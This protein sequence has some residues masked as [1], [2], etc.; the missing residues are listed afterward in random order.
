MAVWVPVVL[1]IFSAGG[2]AHAAVS[3]VYYSPSLADYTIEALTADLPL[4][5]TATVLSEDRWADEWTAVF[6]TGEILKRPAGFVLPASF[7]ASL[8][9][10]FTTESFVA[11]DESRFRFPQKS[12]RVLL[13]LQVDPSL[14]TAVN[15]RDL[16]ILDAPGE[17]RSLVAPFVYDLTLMPVSDNQRVLEI[18]RAELQRVPPT[19]AARGFAVYPLVPDWLP[20]DDRLVP[21][22]RRWVKSDNPLARCLAVEIFRAYP[23]P[24]DTEALKTL[25]NDPYVC[26]MPFWLSPWS[27]REYPV[28]FWAWRALE[29]RGA[30]VPSQFVELPRPGVYRT[31]SWWRLGLL[32]LSPLLAYAWFRRWCRRRKGLP[33]PTF[34]HAAASYLTFVCLCL[35]ALIVTCWHRSM[36]TADDIVFARHS[37]LLDITSI[38]GNVYFEWGRPWPGETPLV[39]AAIT[40]DPVDPSPFNRDADFRNGFGTSTMDNAYSLWD[41][42]I[43]GRREIPRVFYGSFSWVLASQ[44]FGLTGA[45]PSCRG[46]VLA[47]AYSYLLAMLLALPAARILL[48]LY[49]L[50]RK[51]AKIRKGLCWN[52]SYDLRA[53]KPGDRC[54]ECGQMIAARPSRDAME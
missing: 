17:A 38:Q 14:S 22:A 9:F 20:D 54:P 3:G 39:H 53:H 45:C 49:A 32:V 18:V 27:G 36:H 1:L 15:I 11:G 33:R 4:I 21:L 48:A 28:R 37:M 52:C 24:Q 7:D 2:I 47:C 41:C 35:A 29:K 40:P 34:R 50:W 31:V 5:V 30:A 51:A 19:T 43:R 25:L 8:V 10:S 23:D 12:E 42:Y 13:F 6:A 44:P 46:M 26:D 16:V